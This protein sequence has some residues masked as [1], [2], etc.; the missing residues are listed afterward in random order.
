VFA[1]EQRGRV[2]EGP[3]RSR[4]VCFVFPG[5]ERVIGKVR[6]GNNDWER[7]DCLEEAR[8]RE[9]MGWNETSGDGEAWGGGERA[10][11]LSLVEG[12]EPNDC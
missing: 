2:D 1:V 6:I 11:S 12:P 3:S 8:E 4:Y 7:D 9:M 5:R 10:A